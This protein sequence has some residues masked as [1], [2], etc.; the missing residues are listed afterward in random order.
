MDINSLRRDADAVRKQLLTTEAGTV[1]TTQGCKV[2]FPQRFT[3]RSLA[4][5]GTESAV[6]GIFVIVLS[7]GEYCVSSVNALVPMQP[8]SV[9]KVNVQGMD[10]VEFSFEPGSVL[11]KTLELVINDVFV[12]RIYDEF[13]SKGNVPWYMNYDDM[14]SIFDTAEKHGGTKIANNSEVT[15]LIISLIA[16]SDDRTVY[17]RS[18]VKTPED[19][20]TKPLNWIALMS[21]AYAATN[22]LAKLGG[23]HFTEGA[24]SAMVHP[25]DRME[26]IESLVRA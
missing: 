12:Y 10:Y 14:A 7:T 23:S 13:I 3:E 2:Y 5:I 1:I 21:A 9:S 19:L 25:T 16:R 22:T 20:K 8:D 17:Y 24:I 18:T 4:F 6:C 26:K 11:I 15:E